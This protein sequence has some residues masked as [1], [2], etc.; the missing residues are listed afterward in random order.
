MWAKVALDKPL[1]W[2]RCKLQV[3]FWL[4]VS[5]ALPSISRWE[6]GTSSA[7]G[8]N[9]SRFRVLCALREHPKVRCCAQTPILGTGFF[10]LPTSIWHC[11]FPYVTTTML[12]LSVVLWTFPRLS[13]RILL[14]LILEFFGCLAK[15][16]LKNHVEK[17]C[18]YSGNWT[19]T[20]IREHSVRKRSLYAL[21][22]DLSST[23]FL[24][25]VRFNNGFRAHGRRLAFL[26]Y[27]FLDV[28]L[29]TM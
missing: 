14:S 15:W 1:Q 25:L 22:F 18:W 6:D 20:A 7:E 27:H 26:S 16:K 2:P 4:A 11:L 24:S 21:L 12:K 5:A 19:V 29:Q 28:D 9:G 3:L 10:S 8:S 23:T 13:L 17:H